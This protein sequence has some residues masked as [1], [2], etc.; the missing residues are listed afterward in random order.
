MVRL[1]ERL[2]YVHL[3]GSDRG[4][5]GTGNVRRDELFGALSEIGFVGRP[6]MESFGHPDPERTAR[7]PSG[8]TWP[9]TSRNSCA[10]GL[11]FLRAEAEEHGLNLGALA[12]HQRRVQP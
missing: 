7:Q 8:A 5:S 9:T 1:G 3:S 10:G 12:P 11:P 4:T 2:R 6:V